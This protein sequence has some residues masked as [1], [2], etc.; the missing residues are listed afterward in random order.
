MKYQLTNEKIVT[1]RQIKYLPCSRV[2]LRNM[3]LNIS[4]KKNYKMKTLKRQYGIKM[5]LD[6]Q[7][8][9]L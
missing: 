2:K 5:K 8:V 7:V 9:T 4:G 3:N 6:K 1:W